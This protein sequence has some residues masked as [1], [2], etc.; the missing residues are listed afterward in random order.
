MRQLILTI[1]V[2]VTLNACAAA[3]PGS[4]ELVRLDGSSN[5][6]AERSFTRMIKQRDQDKQPELLIAILKLNMAGVESAIDVAADPE[7]QSISVS[8]IKHR[9]DGMTADE[10]IELAETA[11]DVTVEVLIE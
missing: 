11:T 1:A 2:V 6:S 10:I 3:G 5:V 7:L 9:I 4:S 8:R